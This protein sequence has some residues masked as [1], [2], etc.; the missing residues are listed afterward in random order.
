MH[1]QVRV[2]F[3]RSQLILLPLR[4]SLFFCCLQVG[5]MHD[6]SR[7][8]AVTDSRQDHAVGNLSISLQLTVARSAAQVQIYVIDLMVG[9]DGIEPPTFAV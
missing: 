8:E 1:Q 7:F 2:G 5:L 3:V 9:A 6:T 4:S